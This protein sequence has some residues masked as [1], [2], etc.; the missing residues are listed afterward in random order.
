MSTNADVTHR[1]DYCYDQEGTFSF[2]DDYGINR[3]QALNQLISIAATS[4]YGNTT[5]IGL[6]QG[7]VNALFFCRY[8]VS[9]QVCQQ[10]VAEAVSRTKLF[11]SINVKAF[12]VYDECILRYANHTIFGI[13]EDVSMV[14][15]YYTDT[16]DDNGQF[17]RLVASTVTSLINDAIL[18]YPS[19]SRYFAT[20]KENYKFQTIYFLAQCVPDITSSDCRGCLQNSFSNFSANYTGSPMGETFT[21]S[22]FITYN[23]SS[24]SIKPTPSPVWNIPSIGMILLRPCQA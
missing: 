18:G 19:S 5:T 22:C 12:I 4:Y 21:P 15:V 14:H 6:G 20:A 17:S 23:L 13:K 1:Y 2:T 24:N 11:C 7:Q 8:Y 10:C 16:V 3:D 9:P